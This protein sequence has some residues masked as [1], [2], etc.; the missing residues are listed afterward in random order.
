[1][2]RGNFQP[3]TDL[4]PQVLA[5]VLRARRRAARARLAGFA[6]IAG[7]SA[8]FLVPALNYA[9]GEASTSGFGSY[10]SL[11]FSD[12]VAAFSLFADVANSLLESIPALAL[13]AIAIPLTALIFGVWGAAQS[14]RGAL[15]PIIA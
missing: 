4:L 6:A 1:M 11:F 7:V 5:E 2:T 10:L 9:A 8:I 3:P 12:T 14:A 15:A 13:I